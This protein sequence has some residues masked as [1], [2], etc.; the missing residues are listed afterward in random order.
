MTCTLRST[1]RNRAPWPTSSE[2]REISQKQAL[3]RTA[4]H[5]LHVRHGGRMVPFAGYSMPVQYEGLGI[6]ASHLH[7][8]LH[9]SL[10]DVSHMLQSRLHG[11]DRVRFAE[12]LVVSDIQ[13]LA[14]DCGTLTVYT[15]EQGGIIDDLIV[16]KTKDWLY[17]VSNAGCRDK[18]LAHV[19]AK[20]AAFQAAGG[21]AT[22]ELLDSWSLLAL[23]GPAAAELLQPLVD[24]S[25]AQVAFMRG[26][27]VTLAGVPG[28]RLTRCGYTGEDGFELSVP[29]MEATGLAEEL[30]SRSAGRLQLAG[31]GARD[32]LRLEAGLCLYGQDIDE[33]TTPVEAGLTFTIGK[34]R[35]QLADFP[36]AARILEQIR[37]KPRRRRVGLVA[38]SAGPPARSGA[39]VYDAEGSHE[40]GRVTS[41]I[42][43]P[44]LGSNI[45]MAYVPSEHSAAGTKVQLEVRGRRLEATVVKMP[46]VPSHYY[47]GQS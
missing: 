34:R 10:F 23:Q 18:D 25:L 12:S 6:G 15:N 40:L 4:L 9:A 16:N 13:G 24:C 46:F 30:L 27:T 43:S 31:L 29:S 11:P 38:T 45:A 8:R 1:A 37:Q 19:Q 33:Q 20:L 39:T 32:S 36:G 22:L 2:L 42:P 14:E 28:C 47:T 26:A 35:R 17:I 5:E 41:G 21:Q 44:S 3:Q 7:T